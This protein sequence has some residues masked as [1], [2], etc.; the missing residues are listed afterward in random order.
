MV[1]FDEEDASSAALGVCYRVVS[2]SLSADGYRQLRVRSTQIR[3]SS[4]LAIIRYKSTQ[5][6]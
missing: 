3:V 2:V 4:H 6:E 1:R 5:P